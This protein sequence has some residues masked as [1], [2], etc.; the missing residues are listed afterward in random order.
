[1]LKSCLQKLLVLNILKILNNCIVQVFSFSTFEEPIVLNL[2]YTLFEDFIATSLSLRTRLV[3]QI[4]P[5]N[6]VG[7]EKNVLL[8]RVLWEDDSMWWLN[9]ES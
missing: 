2:F 1:M 3:R 9:I 7:I 6:S 4:A 5:M 8:D